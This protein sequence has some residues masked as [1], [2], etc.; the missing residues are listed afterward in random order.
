MSKA[1]LNIKSIDDAMTMES[2]FA[3]E[4]KSFLVAEDNPADAELIKIMLDQVFNDDCSITH[5]ESFQSLLEALEENAFSTLILDMTLPDRSGV[6]NITEISQKYPT[7]PI[8][9]LTGQEDYELAVSSLK[10]GAQDFLSKNRITADS[11]AH[12]LHYAKSQKKAELEL[13]SSLEETAERNTHLENVARHDSLTKLPNRHYFME[14]AE[15]I[16][17]RAERQEKQVALLYYDLNGFKKINDTYGHL[18][19]D[20]LLIQVSN[21]VNDIVRTSDLLARIGGDEFVIITDIFDSKRET[22]HFI[23]RIL[24]RF[25]APFEIDGHS[26]ICK[27]S[28]GIA[29][30]PEADNLEMLIKQADTAMYEAKR[31]PN[32]F[33]CFYTEK[34]AAHYS[35]SQK[36]EMELKYAL[37][38]AEVKAWFQPVF[39]VE[40]PGEVSVEALARWHS[41]LLGWVNPK[42]FIPLAEHSPAI[43]ELSHEM[44]KNSFSFYEYSNTELSAS[45]ATK[46]SINVCASQLTDPNFVSLFTSWV[47]ESQIPPQVICL[48]LS[49]QQ[50]VHSGEACIP[51]LKALQSNG[52]HIALDNFGTGKSSLTHLL[53]Y[54]LDVIKLDRQIIAD[55]DKNV[56]NQAL[57]GGI[58]ETSHRLGMKVVAEGI[59][60]ESEYETMV[61]LGCDYIQ[62]FYISK[63]LPADEVALYYELKNLV[64]EE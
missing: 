29:F 58:L 30:Y 37:D 13:Q 7:L 59:E 14:T 36:I 2:N 63:P 11:L 47:K 35:R 8:V 50:L 62:G 39:N 31:S 32:S 56:R 9:V 60:L 1:D 52:F 25:D 49:E 12:S 64:T 18:A 22:Y 41:P 44:V 15:R 6:M 24:G 43:N 28:I 26:I 19:G 42:D 3:A 27:P 46:I 54:P 17:S 5:V 48:E 21:R 40:H 23:K 33:A 61:E 57:I 53:D 20:E 4:E 45:A 38:N 34:M 51:Q 10:E 16:L 55:I